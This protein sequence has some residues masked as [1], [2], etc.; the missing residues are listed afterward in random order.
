MIL[1]QG[2]G[3]AFSVLTLILLYSITVFSGGAA[4]G[5]GGL[6][7]TLKNEMEKQVAETREPLCCGVWRSMMA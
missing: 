4:V 2:F 6:F 3:H 7:L 1:T 5:F